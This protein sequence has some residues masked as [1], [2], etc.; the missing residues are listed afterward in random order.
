MA[1]K[2]NRLVPARAIHPGEILREELRERGIKQKEFAQL[3]GIQPT[4]LSEF[5]KGKRN[6][7]ENLAMKL[8]QYLGIPYKTWMSL[9]NG[10]V[11]DCK[12]LADKQTE[13]QKARA[14]ES[15]CAEIF[16]LK[17]LYRR[18]DLNT[19]SCFERVRKVKDMFPFDLLS[20]AEL[21]LQVAGLYK[22]SEKVQIDEKNMQTWLILNWLE[23]SL[24]KTGNEYQKGNGLKAA[25]SIAE[26][27]NNRTLTDRAIKE[28]LLRYG[29]LYVNVEKLEKVPVDA[30]STFVGNHPVI[31]VTYRYNDIDKLAFDVLHELC[32]IENHFTEEHKAFIS[33]EGALYSKDPR[34]KEAN[35]FARRHLIPDD[36]WNSMLK[37]GCKSL[38]PHKI[39]T[40]IAE[41]AVRRGISPSVAI[42]RYKHDTNWY[43][44]SAYKSPKIY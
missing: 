16:N 26:M 32:H 42:S 22:H 44:T 34:E 8:E 43:Q 23:T 5:V 36:V 7:N 17:L 14:F 15:A 28:C 12:A 19:L 13:E 9:H 35:D 37:V 33:I 30:Y 4:H 25:D 40:A 21:K 18:L 11:Y 10:Y 29:I 1:T 20:S 3:I 38:S 24:A 6:L 39:V 2:N 27:A 31:T 41:E